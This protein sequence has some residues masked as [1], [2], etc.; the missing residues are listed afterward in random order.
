MEYR[1][2][3]TAPADGFVQCTRFNGGKQRITAGTKFV[4]CEHWRDHYGHGCLWRYVAA[5][6]I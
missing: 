2:G 5:P 3:E 1:P 4:P 6:G